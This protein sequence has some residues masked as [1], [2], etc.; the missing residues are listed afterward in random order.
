MNRPSR[1]LLPVNISL[2]PIS[3]P[4]RRVNKTYQV[5]AHSEA[6]LR[7]V[8]PNLGQ[9]IRSQI[10]HIDPAI[11]GGA[12]QIPAIFTERDR[13]DLARFVAVCSQNQ[14]TNV[15]KYHRVRA[16]RTNDLSLSLPYAL[17]LSFLFRDT[18]YLHLT[19]KAC[20][21]CY[22]AVLARDEMVDT[23]FMYA[24]KRLY[25]RKIRFGRGMDTY[26]RGAR[27]REECGFCRRESEDVG[28]M[29]CRSL[30]EDM[31]R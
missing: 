10:P 29:S 16:I 26:R 7:F 9:S 15:L 2:D 24:F 1:D 28:R 12:G 13:P 25:E 27:G 5:N 31:Q 21:S 19:L 3:R 8:L 6:S 4:P 30:L 11:I 23:E 14:L 22:F 17:L 18:P 20:A